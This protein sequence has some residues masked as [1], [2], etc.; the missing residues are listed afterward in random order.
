MAH[1]LWSKGW[2]N[3]RLKD[4]SLGA[5]QIFAAGL[6]LDMDRF[7]KDEAGPDCKKRLSDDATLAAL[8]GVRGTPG[9][10]INGR[11]LSGAQPVDNFIRIIDEEKAKA[12]VS[13]LQGAAH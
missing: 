9:F 8:L 5:A 13:K 3:D 7:K 12:D 2:E 11:F 4:I 1:L 6:G 10:Y